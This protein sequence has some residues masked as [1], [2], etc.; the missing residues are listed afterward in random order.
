MISSVSPVTF[1]GGISFATPHPDL[2]GSAKARLAWDGLIEVG[3]KRYDEIYQKG[4]LPGC[5][6]ECWRLSRNPKPAIAFIALLVPA[7]VVGVCF[8]GQETTGLSDRVSNP[9]AVLC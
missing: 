5:A 1:H 2:D 8:D 3:Q 6:E 7:L 4:D 9:A